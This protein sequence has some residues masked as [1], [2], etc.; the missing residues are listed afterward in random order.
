[1]GGGDT[2][3]E[4]NRRRY[5]VILKSVRVQNF[6]CVRDS[7]PFGVDEKV[8]CLVGKN[9]SGKTALLQ[10]LRKLS[11][12]VPEDGKFEDL[13]YPRIFWTDY[14]ARKDKDPAPAL[15]T[16]WTLEPVDV[17]A[18]QGV[19]GMAFDPN[20]PVGVS[21][22]YDN[23][24][25][26][27]VAVDEKATVTHLLNRFEVPEEERQD[28]VAAKTVAELRANLQKIQAPSQPVGQLREHVNAH[29]NGKTAF[30]VASAA[31]LAR[32]P[33]FVY[34]AENLTL[35]GK[36]AMTDL[37]KRKDQK[38]QD[39]KLRAFFAFLAF[40]GT[41]PEELEKVGGFERLQA[42][43]EAASAKLTKDIFRYWSQNKHLRV[44]FRFEK[45]L[46]TDP[47]PFND[48]FVFRT[49]IENTRHSSTTSFDDRSTGFV[50]FFS[51]LVWFS[52][53]RKNYGEKLILLLDEPG[54]GLHAKAQED[55]L[56]YIEE[57]L[58][59]HYQVI[60]TTH[61]P[62]M[63][64]ASH[65]MR[66]RTVEDV[67]IEP[68]A[69]ALVPDERDMG[70]KVGDEVLSTDRDTLSALQRCLG[71]H[72]VQTLF[73]GKHNLLVEG[74]SDLLYLRWFQQRLAEKK[75]TTLDRRWTIAPCE[76]LKKVGSFISLFGANGLHL[77]VFADLATGEKAEVERLRRSQL[78]KDGA[79]LT[80][81]T[82]AG[83]AEA[84]I[85]DLLGDEFYAALV[86][87]TYSLTNS[88]QV[89]VPPLGDQRRN[90][91]VVKRVEDH[92]RTLPEGVDE[93]DHFRP[94]EHLMSLGQSGAALPGF[95]DACRRFE[96]LFSDLN[97]LLPP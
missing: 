38:P 34:F 56:R 13:E 84:D 75:R 7:R 93:F 1:V 45:G 80:A 94:A 52:Q 95:A 71:L 8:T 70:T 67:F 15:D 61:S 49:R 72:I 46:P 17:E 63:I 44:Q 73:V 20:V 54:L 79:V 29:F 90:Q 83:K 43:L 92:F 26:C 24:S 14:K 97:P 22:G 2:A 30:D 6:K 76:G 89:Q 42:E 60:Y 3:A 35:P 47:A 16:E 59:P 10:S 21:K 91:R 31:I 87:R 64:D 86:N 9:E 50:W 40:V 18:L 32:L 78:L 28:L 5:V 69:G 82:Y 85:E 66:A 74:P 57:Q 37:T 19:I 53:A 25:R 96:R 77:A 62:S 27:R 65:L 39:Q 81:D 58:A 4:S 23:V 33:R 68:R 41:T 36:V 48:G 88:N 51:F 12:D 11:P 55:L